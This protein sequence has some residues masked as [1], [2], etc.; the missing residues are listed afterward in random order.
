MKYRL[1]TATTLETKLGSTGSPCENAISSLSQTKQQ[2]WDTHRPATY[3]YEASAA[4]QAPHQ[5]CSLPTLPPGCHCPGLHGQ[6]LQ[7]HQSLATS[8]NISHQ[9]DPIIGPMMVVLPKLVFPLLGGCFWDGPCLSPHSSLWATSPIFKCLSSVKH[10]MQASIAAGSVAAQRLQKLCTIS[11][12]GNAAAP[13]LC[14]CCASTLSGNVAVQ[15]L[16]KL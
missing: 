7:H 4:D 1:Q 9:N 6:I 16:Q 15:R 11:G 8:T 10:G 2:S 13:L 12:V 14:K 3:S 5:L